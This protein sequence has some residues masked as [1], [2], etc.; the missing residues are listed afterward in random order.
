[1]LVFY[2][3]IYVYTHILVCTDCFGRRSSMSSRCKNFLPI[4]LVFPLLSPHCTDAL[5]KGEKYAPFRLTEFVLFLQLKLLLRT[6]EKRRQLKGAGI[7]WQNRSRITVKG[8]SRLEMIF[9][10][11]KTDWCHKVALKK[12]IFQNFCSRLITLL[13]D[14]PIFL[15]FSFEGEWKSINLDV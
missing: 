8:E 5:G 9:L 13:S 11:L 1:M 3:S 4:C 14:C 10:A 7:V 2:S 12:R 6:T 15:I